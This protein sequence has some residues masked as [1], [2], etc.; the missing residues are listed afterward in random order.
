M[1]TRQRDRSGEEEVRA[2]D[3]RTTG[4]RVRT[5]RRDPAARTQEAWSV[6][7]AAS[8]D[9]ADGAKSASGQDARAD[10]TDAWLPRRLAR[11]EI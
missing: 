9:D 8:T 4:D 10:A 6:R 11:C 5:G 1:T 2:A 3:S 7:G